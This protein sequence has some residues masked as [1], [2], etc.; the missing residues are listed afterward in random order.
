MADLEGGDKLEISEPG[1]PGARETLL[2]EVDDL[3]SKFRQKVAGD[4]DNVDFG[5]HA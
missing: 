3:R 2:P 4:L 1:M 5:G